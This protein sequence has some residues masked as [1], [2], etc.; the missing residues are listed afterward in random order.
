MQV[1]VLAT[2]Q[3]KG[4]LF[5]QAKLDAYVSE[6]TSDFG[7]YPY[8]RG[9]VPNPYLDKLWNTIHDNQ[10]IPPLVLHCEYS[11]EVAEGKEIELDMSKVEILDGLQRTFRLWGYYKLAQK[12]EANGYEDIKALIT[13]MKTDFPV[14]FDIGFMKFE[15]L[16][17]WYVSQKQAEV[18][19]KYRESHIYFTLWTHLSPEE[20][21]N[22]FLLLNVGQKKVSKRHQLE[23][24]FLYLW[25]KIKNEVE[26]VE[27]IR[28][29]DANAYQIRKGNR[30]I[31]QLMFSSV[32]M[33]YRSLFAQKALVLDLYDFIAEI[34]EDIN[35]NMIRAEIFKLF[36]IQLTEID[37]L[38]F[39][40]EGEVA[41][42]WF[43][44]D[45]TLCGICGGMGKYFSVETNGELETYFNALKTAITEYGFHI[46]DFE[47]EMKR[48]QYD[49]QNMMRKAIAEYT[50]LLLAG[51]NPV[52]SAIFGELK[53]KKTER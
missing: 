32:V 51:N 8:Q 45:T 16:K 38:L 23:L 10:P 13:D 18:L 11:D 27:L 14:L 31:G 20:L 44:H 26:G 49:V 24:L 28:E 2:N 34:D 35:E 21:V 48:V 37:A 17:D 12:L 22:Q 1:K 9:F 36:V 7:Q 43:V 42:K 3:D 50:Y 6:L 53:N 33:A 29:R 41:K 19:T 52:W 4:W 5:C 39:T 40:Q 46:T 25:E 15:L 30:Q 47:I